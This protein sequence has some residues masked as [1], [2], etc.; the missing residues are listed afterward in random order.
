MMGFAKRSTRPER[1]PGS[2]HFDE[3]F[4]ALKPAS[5]CGITVSNHISKSRRRVFGSLIPE[6]SC[7]RQGRKKT[8]CAPATRR[9]QVSGERQ[10]L[11]QANVSNNRYAGERR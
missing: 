10:R 1:L 3:R 9:P 6:Q 5:I 4:A 11:W 2:R 7:S 8:A